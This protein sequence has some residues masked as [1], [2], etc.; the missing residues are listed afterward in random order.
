MATKYPP[1][2]EKAVLA[3]RYRMCGLTQA[4]TGGLIGVTASTISQWEQSKWWA[5]VCLEATTVEFSLMAA[6]ALGVVKQK[7][8]EGDVNTARWFLGKAH[9]LL[10]DRPKQTQSLDVTQTAAAKRLKAHPDFAKMTEDQL[11]AL[12][13][14]D[15]E[16]VILELTH[17]D[18]DP[19]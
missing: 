8:E 2:W 19:D 1:D 13:F 17:D 14:G 15:P 11:R 10:S 12:A 9:P 3:A 6:K 16:P 18:E 5:E 4:E 7:I